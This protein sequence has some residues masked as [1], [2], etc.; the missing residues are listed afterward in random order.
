M[1][2]RLMVAIEFTTP[3]QKRNGRP[4]A[5]FQGEPKGSP[6]DWPRTIYLKGGSEKLVWIANEQH[7]VL[8]HLLNGRYVKTCVYDLGKFLARYIEHNEAWA[9]MY[10]KSI[11]QYAYHDVIYVFPEEEN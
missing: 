8:K 4:V 11:H 10:E 2:R 5:V 3:D 6:A 1:R 7:Y 9:F